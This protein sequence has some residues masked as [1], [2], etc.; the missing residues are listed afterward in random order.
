LI[1]ATTSEIDAFAA[2]AVSCPSI[3]I[4]PAAAGDLKAYVRCAAFAS[5]ETSTW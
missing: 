3:V 4:V 1:A 5:C 2:T